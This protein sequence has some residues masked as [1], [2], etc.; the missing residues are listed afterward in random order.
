MGRLTLTLPLLVPPPAPW[1]TAGC[2]WAGG[3][4]SKP[5]HSLGRP[6]RAEHLAPSQGQPDTS[7]QKVFMAPRPGGATPGPVL[8]HAHSSLCSVSAPWK[9]RGPPW[10]L[11][12]LCTVGPAFFRDRAVHQPCRASAK[13][14]PCPS[15]VQSHRDHGDRL[16]V[17]PGLLV[18]SSVP[19][20]GADSPRHLTLLPCEQVRLAMTGTEGVWPRVPGTGV[21]P[22][23]LPA[24]TRAG[25]SEEGTF[26]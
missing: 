13:W 14:V 12:P 4:V 20:L 26:E 18:A 10:R 8:G 25:P 3:A 17:S 11:L 15:C 5:R 9:L 1:A 21:H 2:G 22:R 24:G 23:T 16:T 7:V 19:A 6:G